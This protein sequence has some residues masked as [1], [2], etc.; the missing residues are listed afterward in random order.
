MQLQVLLAITLLGSAQIYTWVDDA[1]QRHYSDVPR[2]GAEPVTVETSPAAAPQ[3]VASP[4]QVTGRDAEPEEAPRYE[5]LSIRSPA[6][7]ETLWNIEGQ[8][9]VALDLRPALRDGHTLLL[10]LDNQQAAV[11]QGGDTV[12]RLSEVWR[13]ER[14][15]R[16]EVRDAANQTLIESPTIRF[17]VQ[18]TSI[19]NPQNPLAPAVP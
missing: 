1:G 19:A 18:Q 13:G 11:L 8:L 9:D 5:S 6:Q 10:F 14:L 7:D 2:P 15:L 4:R 17:F 12:A 3:P 16:A